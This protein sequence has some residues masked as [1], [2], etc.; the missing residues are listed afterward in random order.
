M[1]SIVHRLEPRLR[2]SV[3]L[4]AALDCSGAVKR[5]SQKLSSALA[6]FLVPPSAAPVPA[7]IRADR[8]SGVSSGAFQGSGLIQHAR[9][10]TLSL[11]EL[12]GLLLC[13]QPL[14]CLALSQRACTTHIWSKMAG[15]SRPSSRAR[16]HHSSA[17]DLDV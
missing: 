17:A 5:V 4:R 13:W 16:N 3:L 12:C 11:S 14:S 15:I 2:L 9:V 7:K 10:P 1:H 6:A 8:R